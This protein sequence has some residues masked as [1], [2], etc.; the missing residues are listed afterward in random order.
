MEL[1]EADFGILRTV[2]IHDAV[3]PEALG[4]I[5]SSVILNTAGAIPSRSTLAIYLFVG[6]FVQ[7]LVVA[8]NGLGVYYWKWPRAGHAVAAYGYPLWLAGTLSITIG[9]A[10]C[11]R[12][13]ESSTTELTLRPKPRGGKSKLDS[14]LQIL[15]LQE[16]DSALSL[17]AY[18]IR[19]KAGGSQVEISIHDQLTVVQ[20]AAFLRSTLLEMFLT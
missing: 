5:A 9:I 3:N 4:E 20:A 6:T 1:N 17:P 15:R 13:I 8:V 19:N 16:K 14:P 12:V 7:A 10:F 2:G 18:A 11:A